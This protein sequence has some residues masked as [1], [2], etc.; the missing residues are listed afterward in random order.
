VLPISVLNF[1]LE[2]SLRVIRVSLVGGT[3]F[4]LRGESNLADI[5]WMCE[6][7]KMIH[8]ESGLTDH[9]RT[10]LGRKFSE[11]PFISASESDCNLPGLSI[12]SATQGRPRESGSS[13]LTKAGRRQ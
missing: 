6:A 9:I 11:D 1:C 10:P 13:I 2:E 12:Q 4:Q 3:D 8:S 5:H 7:S